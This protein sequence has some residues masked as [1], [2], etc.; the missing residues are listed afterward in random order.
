[1]EMNPPLTF[2]LEVG[3]VMLLVLFIVW[4]KPEYGLFLYGL[5]LGFP[6]IAIPLGSAIHIRIDDVL[7]VLFLLRSL[8]W[9]PAPIAPGQRKILGWQALFMALCL[10]SAAV[11]I[12]RGTPPAMYETV[13]MIGCAAILAILPRLVQ[14]ER[15]LR[16]LIAGLMCAGAALVIQVVLRLGGSSPKALANF[17]ELKYA[18][19]FTTWNPNTIG[20]AAMLLVFA[21]GMGWIISPKSRANSILWFCLAAAF[22]LT[23][24]LVFARGT[25]LSIAAGFILFVCLARRWKLA[26]MFVVVC[27]SAVVYLRGVNS[28]LV[29]GATRV[30]LA[31]GEGFSHR[32]ERWDMA[33][34]A[35]KS[36]PLLGHGFGQEWTLLSSLGS[37]GRAH[38][39]YMSVWIELGIGGLALLLA[40]VYQF[41]SIGRSLCRRPGFQLCGALLLALTAAM[42]L[43]SAGLPTLYWEKLPTISLAIGIAL[44]G[45]CEREHLESVTELARRP[46]IEALLE[47][48]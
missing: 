45:I 20:Q 24:V 37:E 27:L 48:S 28:A 22:A 44:A 34:E 46:C 30:N 18:A 1:M 3:I 16:F 33:A 43:D 21:A 7:I 40:V 47:Q 38:N 23:P 15:R 14:S 25:S 29:D 9:K 5:A 4:V 39:A 13:K 35:I 26:L 31:T 6:D 12:A 17:Q 32:Y 2:G 42:C 41:V 8:L 19:T 10:L 36:A 11:G